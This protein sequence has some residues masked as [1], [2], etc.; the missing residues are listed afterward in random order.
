MFPDP[1][2]VLAASEPDGA[3]HA[4]GRSYR[5]ALVGPSPLTRRSF[6]G[7]LGG[8]VASGCAT[9]PV[10]PVVPFVPAPDLP[11]RY[12][13]INGGFH[14]PL[15]TSLLDQLAAVGRPLTLRSPVLSV[16]QATAILASLDPYPSLTCLL[17]V[18]QHDL[19]LLSSLLSV[20]HHPRLVGLEYLNEPD[21][22]R[23]D[24]T[25]VQYADAVMAA[26]RMLRDGSWPTDILSGGIF[27]VEATED[28][29]DWHAHTYLTPLLTEAPAD[30]VIGLHWYGDTSDAWLQRVRD[31]V[32]GRSIAITEFGQASRTPTEDTAQAAYLQAQSTA[33]HRLGH[34]RY[35]LPYQLVSGPSSSDLDNFGLL[36]VDGS[37]KPAFALLSTL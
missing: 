27:S 36:R 23:P 28:T 1:R 32:G 35:A 3:L 9:L 16:A 29:G 26:Y 33:F 7:A 11:I 19:W 15:P 17:L 5:A 12:V 13:G 37:P 8:L 20:M 2:A 4:S 34:V 22:W 14:A 6:C 25:P 21:L 31:L 24:F 30:L 18:E 10:A